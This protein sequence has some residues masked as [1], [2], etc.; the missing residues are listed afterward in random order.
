MAAG[1]ADA[2]WYQPP[3]DLQRLRALTERN[4]LDDRGGSL[5]LA[6]RTSGSRRGDG[7]CP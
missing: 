1:L 3:I 2:Q 7:G 5:R 4:K 6:S